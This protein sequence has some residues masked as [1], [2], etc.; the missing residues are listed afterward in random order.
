[1]YLEHLEISGSPHEALEN[2][3]TSN[4]TQT[5]KVV[6][7]GNIANLYSVDDWF[8]PCSGQRLS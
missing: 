2:T 6:L 7:S 8:E 3:M 5:R 1:M 4:T